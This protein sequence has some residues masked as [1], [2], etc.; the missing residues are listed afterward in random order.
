MFI[1]GV[2][3]VIDVMSRK[4]PSLLRSKLSAPGP[5]NGQRSSPSA[6]GNVCSGRMGYGPS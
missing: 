3:A 1:G 6:E 4:D 2:I 5:G